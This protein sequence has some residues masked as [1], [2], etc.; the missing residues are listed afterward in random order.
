VFLG[1]E[2]QTL[3]VQPLLQLV[4][5]DLM[6]LGE[7]AVLLHIQEGLDLCPDLSVL[8]HFI[9]HSCLVLWR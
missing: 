7:P 4:P 9:V 6:E 8:A 1:R 2:Q 3:T 5:Q